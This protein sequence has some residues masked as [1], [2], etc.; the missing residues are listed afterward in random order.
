[1]ETFLSSDKNVFTVLQWSENIHWKLDHRSLD[2]PTARQLP[3]SSVSPSSG[4][5]WRS[6]LCR[7][8]TVEPGFEP[9]SGDG[10]A[11]PE[12]GGSLMLSVRAYV[13]HSDLL[14]NDWRILPPD[15]RIYIISIYSCRVQRI[16]NYT[17][18]FIFLFW[19]II[20]QFWS[21]CCSIW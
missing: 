16:S 5:P 4:R 20:G 6:A 10:A 7:F 14:K 8:G 2:R 11:P 1:M 13:R 3:V 9:T 12:A 18:T 19:N 21:R 17:L 15:G